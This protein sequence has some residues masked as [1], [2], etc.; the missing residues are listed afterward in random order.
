MDYGFHER[1]S[2]FRAPFLGREPEDELGIMGAQM[3]FRSAPCIA[4]ALSHMGGSGCYDLISS[5]PRE[6]LDACVWWMRT[7]RDWALDPKS[8]VPVS[9]IH[10]GLAAALLTFSQP[11]DGVVLSAPYWSGAY[12]T[13]VNNGRTP[14]TNPLI[15]TGDH[16]EIDFDDL[17]KKLAEPKNTM[18]FLCNPHNPIMDVWEERDLR[19]IA[20]LAKKYNVMVVADEIFAEQT[21][22]GVVCFPYAS[23]EDAKDHCLSFFSLG[24]AFNFTGV[25]HANAVVPNEENRTRFKRTAK[26][27]GIDRLSPFMY[28]ATMAAYTPDGADWLAA[29]RDYMAKNEKLM[30][31]FL[32]EHLPDVHICRHRAGSLVWIDWTGLH[33]TAEEFRTYIEKDAGMLAEFADINGESGNF[34]RWEIGFP[35]KEICSQLEALYYGGLKWGISKNGPAQKK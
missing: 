34:L 16:Y 8:L 22:D 28:T 9:G 1:S 7:Q 24:K 29:A 6:Y 12:N 23:I 25:C 15:Y 10:S 20:A 35:Y 13:I 19:E 31:G 14:V 32:A 17:E 21:F 26:A 5:P 3:R 30:R 4:D 27:L 18:Y 11:G 33:M 2:S